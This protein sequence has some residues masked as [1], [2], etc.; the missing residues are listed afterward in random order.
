LTF[1]TVRGSIA[2]TKYGN[3]VVEMQADTP[4]RIGYAR[5]STAHQNTDRQI[6]ALL[7]HGVNKRDIYTD[8]MSGRNFDRPQY[9]AMKEHLAAGD[10]LVIVDLD[11]LGRNY[12]DMAI[13][14]NDLTKNRQ[15]NVE[16][17]NFP[18]LSMTNKSEQL[19]TRLIADVIFALL[20][21]VAQREREHLLERQREGIEVA[22]KNGVK[23]GRPMVERPTEFTSVYAQVLR[24]EITNRRAMELLGLKP[25]VYYRFANEEKERIRIC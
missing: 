19:E 6:T 25:N 14:W 24:H 4:R 17:I 15:C 23:F 20:S 11:R 2:F 18:L 9:L 21:Y 7:E 12:E 13:E 3:G 8:H 5:V 22:K 10:T 1:Q 16:V